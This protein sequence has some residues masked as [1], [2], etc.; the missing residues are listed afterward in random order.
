M[1][2]LPRSLVHVMRSMGVDALGKW[3][4]TVHPYLGLSRSFTL[5]PTVFRHVRIFLLDENLY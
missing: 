1:Y 3:F 4:C 2:F 5:L